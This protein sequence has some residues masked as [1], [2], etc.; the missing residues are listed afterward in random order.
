MFGMTAVCPSCDAEIEVGI[1]PQIG[2]RLDCPVCDASLKIIWLDPIEL[3]WWD[4]EDEYDDFESDMDDEDEDEFEDDIF[5]SIFADDEDEKPPH[6][7]GQERDK[8][9]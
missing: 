7:N 6:I 3:D 8:A 4:E 2:L 5:D 1:T 9:F